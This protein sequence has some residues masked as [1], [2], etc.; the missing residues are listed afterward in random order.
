MN[1]SKIFITLAIL[2][3]GC[4]IYNFKGTNIPP[5]IETFSVAMFNNE[6]EI[7]NP[8]LALQLTE[9]LKNKFQSETK[10]SI[11][12]DNGDYHF[13]GAIKEY[14]VV[15]AT[16]DN[17]TGTAQ[18]QFTISVQV[19]FECPK[20]PEKNFTRSFSFFRTFNASSE[21]STV[22]KELSEEIMDNIV[23]QIFAATALDW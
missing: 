20:F 8:Q 15:P 18:N 4:G 9:K 6:A 2:L 17:N 21:F 19:L 12:N 10:L 3:S 1:L 16:L 23:Q 11:R 5:E 22:E 13:S 7:I 14:K